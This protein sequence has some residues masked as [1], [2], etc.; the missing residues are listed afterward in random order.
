MFARGEK[1]RMR[2]QRRAARQGGGDAPGPVK[3]SR[4]VQRELAER[5]KELPEHEKVRYKMAYKENYRKYAERMA[6]WRAKL[7]LV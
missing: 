3:S 6:D 4:Q 1:Q 5:W 2:E 7:R